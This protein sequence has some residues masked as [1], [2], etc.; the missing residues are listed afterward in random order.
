M[1]QYAS[2]RCNRGCFSDSDHRSI[3]TAGGQDEHDQSSKPH[4]HPEHR[5]PGAKGLDAHDKKPT[6]EHGIGFEATTKPA[7][8]A[9]QTRH[10]A[11]TSPGC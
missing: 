2:G 5:E 7:N 10:Y 9:E 8:P 6:S 3:V 4:D 1:L 11:I